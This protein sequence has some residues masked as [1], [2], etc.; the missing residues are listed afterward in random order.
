MALG[1]VG[2][3]IYVNQQTPFTSTKATSFLNRVDEQSFVDAIDAAKV[4]KEVQKV[5]PAE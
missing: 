3:A 2:N 4:Q 5:R 1:P